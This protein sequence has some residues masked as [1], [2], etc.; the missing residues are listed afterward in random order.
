MGQ[1]FNLPSEKADV[2]IVEDGTAKT[3]ALILPAGGTVSA[4][5]GG[6]VLR[7]STDGEKAFIGGWNLRCYGDDERQFTLDAPGNILVS[8]RGLPG[9]L[10]F[11]N[12]GNKSVSVT[13][14]KPFA[15]TAALDPGQWTEVSKDGN[16]PAIFPP[17]PFPPLDAAN[18]APNLTQTAI[19]SKL[20]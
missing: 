3:F 9:K 6:L 20:L 19:P 11:F 13:L 4:E 15:V 8:S 18:A 16:R 14:T 5:A 10:L 17:A 12:A 7:Q 1:S 2:A